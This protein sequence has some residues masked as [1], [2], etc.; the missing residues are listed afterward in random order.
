VSQSEEEL[1]GTGIFA[2]VQG[3]LKLRGTVDLSDGSF[4]ERISGR[5]CFPRR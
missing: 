4:T 3:R 1:T 5:L 2:G